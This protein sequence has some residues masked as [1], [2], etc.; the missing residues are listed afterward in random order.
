MVVVSPSAGFTGA[1]CSASSRSFVSRVGESKLAPQ[2]PRPATSKP[3]AS[4]FTKA[5][6]PRV[7]HGPRGPAEKTSVQVHGVSRRKWVVKVKVVGTGT[8]SR[9]AGLNRSCAGGGARRFVEGGVAA[10]PADGDGEDA[11]AGVQ[12]DDQQ[13]VGLDAGRAARIRVVRLHFVQ[14]ARRRQDAAR[15]RNAPR[16]TVGSGGRIDGGGRRTCGGRRAWFPPGCHRRRRR[17]PAPPR[18]STRARDRPP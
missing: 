2:P 12:R 7:A 17:A 5:L 13:D 1:A 16:D 10:A 18:T 15:P 9:R 11:A 8:P 14:A 3:S 6:A 4:I